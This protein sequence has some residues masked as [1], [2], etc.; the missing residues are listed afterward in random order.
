[1]NYRHMDYIPFDI[2]NPHC[3]HV[4]L[5]K[6]AYVSIVSEVL[7]HNRNE[8]GGLLIGYI[9]GRR[10]YVLDVVD[11]GSNAYHSE[12]LFN[13]EGDY[14][15]TM[16]QKMRQLYRYQPTILGFWHRHPGSMDYFSQQDVESTQKNLQY[17]KKGLISMLVNVDPA[18]RMTFY[19]C[20]GPHFM[21]VRYDVGD[22]YFP[23]ELMELA[24][25]ELVCRR[26]AEAAGR[27]PV[28]LFYERVIQPPHAPGQV[29]QKTVRAVN[30]AP[31]QPEPREAPAGG[32]TQQT[33]EA[34]PEAHENFFGEVRHEFH[35]SFQK[36]QKKLDAVFAEADA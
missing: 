10:W 22:E 33:R 6:R 28:E 18:L 34:E 9:V 25:P 4:I 36:L 23:V 8:T 21:P 11:P 7:S 3:L 31:Q 26:H 17:A 14:V 15:N 35:A 1:M 29:P 30:D 24:D 13:W 27:E 12:V 20:N 2:Q 19:Y 5:S 32:Q 16:A